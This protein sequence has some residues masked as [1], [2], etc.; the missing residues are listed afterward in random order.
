[1]HGWQ[2]QDR[3]EYQAGIYNYKNSE[4]QKRILSNMHKKHQK[5]YWVCWLRGI[6]CKSREKAPN[7]TAVRNLPIAK[8]IIYVT[9]CLTIDSCRLYESGIVYIST[10]QHACLGTLTLF[11][12]S[13]FT[14]LFLTKM[15][16]HKFSVTF[17]VDSRAKRGDACQ[18]KINLFIHTYQV[19][20]LKVIGYMM[21]ITFIQQN[22]RH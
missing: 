17:F 16:L 19:G 1:M 8:L 14:F 10:H 22:G 5:E 15:Y 9:R 7:P 3:R 11:L 4:N 13:Y 12:D 6:Q 18:M 2:W 20:I 21:S